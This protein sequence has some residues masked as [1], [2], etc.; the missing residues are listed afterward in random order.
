LLIAALFM[1]TIKTSFQLD[2]VQQLKG[3]C[4]N[5]DW[6]CHLATFFATTINYS[7]IANTSSLVIEVSSE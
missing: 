5:Y 1:E 2:Y 7:V 6:P 4:Q 3:Y